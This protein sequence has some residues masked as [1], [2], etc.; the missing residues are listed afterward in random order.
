MPLPIRQPR[1]WPRY[2]TARHGERCAL[3]G[4]GFGGIKV[5]RLFGGRAYHQTCWDRP[6]WPRQAEVV[7]MWLACDPPVL[8]DYEAARYLHSR[9]LLVG[10]L[11]LVRVLPRDY[12]CPP[13]A[14]YG[15][16][17]WAAL[18][19]RLIVPVYDHRGQLRLVRGWRWDGVEPKRVAAAGC[20]VRGLVMANPVALELLNAR[21]DAEWWQAPAKV[22]IVEGEPDWMT[23][24]AA[25]RDWAV[26]G[27]AA[28]SWSEEL[29]ERIPSG[30]RVVIWTDDDDAG[31]KYAEH[32]AETLRGRCDVKRAKAEEKDDLL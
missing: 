16:R 9:G 18:G 30:A 15:G 2:D 23:A 25:W 14:K 17:S 13:W 10:G 19:Y 1:D 27:I 29:A 26:I 24:A 8:A 28:G 20:E 22:A 11:N 32:I 21:P 3:C 12:P 4:E 5:V 6:R 7:D 31:D